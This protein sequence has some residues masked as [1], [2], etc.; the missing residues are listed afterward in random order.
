MCETASVERMSLPTKPKIKI[1]QISTGF[2]TGN[3]LPETDGLDVSATIDR[4]ADLLKTAIESAYPDADVSVD[5]QDAYGELPAP[6]KT[7]VIGDN[8]DLA[9][10]EEDRAAVDRIAAGVFEAGEFYVT[11]EGAA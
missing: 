11:A 6:L 3:L 4:Y 8:D 1:M 9:E 5:W 7:Q 2:L 10:D